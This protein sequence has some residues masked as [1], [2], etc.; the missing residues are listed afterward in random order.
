M[1]RSQ[2]V[3]SQ[4]QRLRRQFR[5]RRNDCDDADAD[6]ASTR[7][8]ERLARSELMASADPVAGYMARGQEVDVRTYL[9]GALNRD[10]RVVLPRVI[11]PGN[12][13]FCRLEGWDELREGAFGIDE[14][15]GPAVDTDRIE[16][17]LVPGLAFDEGGTRLGFGMGFYDRAL[18]P[19]GEAT[20][21]GIGYHWQLVDEPLPAEA[22]DR[23][24]DHVVTDD[25]WHRIE[26]A[27][28]HT[29]E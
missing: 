13:E 1:T 10:T 21:I 19:V 17:F 18:P 9:E 29:R 6:V 27:G 14:P 11:G 28:E 16:V 15:T 3:Q 7:V 4:K 20:A 22:H 23:P 24:M 8:C 12:M 5:T 25:G 2:A 26:S